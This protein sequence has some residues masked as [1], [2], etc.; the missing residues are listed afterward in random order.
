MPPAAAADRPLLGLGVLDCVV[1][2][3]VD[4]DLDVWVVVGA[5]LG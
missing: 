5:G 2:M 1:L 3:D 4:V